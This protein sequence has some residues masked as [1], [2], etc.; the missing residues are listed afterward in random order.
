M[1]DGPTKSQRAIDELRGRIVAGQWQPGAQLPTRPELQRQL[2]VSH[3]T[4]QRVID[5]LLDEGFLRSNRRAG[6]FVADRPPHRSRYAMLIPFYRPEDR[7]GVWEALAALGREQETVDRAHSLAVFHNV[8]PER[9]DPAVYAQLVEQVQA[10]RWAGLIFAS[11]PHGLAGTPLVEEPGIPRVVVNYG[12]GG[13]YKWPAVS[14]DWARWIERAAEATRAAGHARVALIG[15]DHR[16]LDPLMQLAAERHGL[17]AP[18][19]WRL[20]LS[21]AIPIG[22]RRSAALLMSL[23]AEQ[24][25]QTLLVSDDHLVEPVALGLAD[26]GVSVPDQVQVIA[27]ANLPYTPGS[28]IP[29]TY[30]GYDMGAVLNECIGSIDRQRQGE[31]VPWNTTV[32]PVFEHELSTEVPAGREAMAHAA[33]RA[34]SHPPVESAV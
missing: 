28:A 6:T 7:T 17:H 33:T 16:T 5:R 34:I 15:E 31:A 21:H 14:F 20:Y 10:H 8:W 2:G 23:P 22:V 3:A 11:A 29:V 27:H 26:A 4:L 19:H 18:A 30:L 1:A 32:P 24:R 25:P 9:R 12:V 13:Q